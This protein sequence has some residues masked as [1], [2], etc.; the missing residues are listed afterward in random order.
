VVLVLVS[1]CSFYLNRLG[2]LLLVPWFSVVTMH[3]AAFFTALLAPVAVSAQLH[4]LAVRAGLKYFGTAIREGAT[5]NDAA[6]MAIVNNK[7]E[8]GAVVAENGQKWESIQRTRGVFDYS[9]GDITANIARRN[10]QYMR[11]HTLVWHSQ[12]P[13]WGESCLPRMGTTA[14]D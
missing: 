10:G 12:L 9:Q 8:F 11:C 2:I 7:N 4:D 13:S 1:L 6:Y 3:T 5:N 14:N